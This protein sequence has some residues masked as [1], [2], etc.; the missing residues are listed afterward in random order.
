METAETAGTIFGD[1]LYQQR[2]RRALPLLVRQAIA[3]QTITYEALAREL[4]MPNPR[5]LNYVLGSIGETLSQLS[6]EWNQA[7]PKIQ[8]L[9]VNKNLGIPGEGIL[10]FLPEQQN[11]SQLPLKQKRSIVNTILSEVYVYPHWPKVLKELSLDPPKPLDPDKGITKL[12]NSQTYFGGGEGKQHKAL[13][14]RVAAHPALIG[15]KRNPISVKIEHIL[16]SGDS[17]D[18]HFLYKTESVAVEVKSAISTEADLRRGMFQCIKYQV[19]MEAEHAL[20]QDA[21]D[22][23]TLLVVEGRLSPELVAVKNTLGVEVIELDENT[24]L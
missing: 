20:A 12:F 19:V 23:K 13:K 16:A 24:K 4:E 2:A 14:E 11:F 5:N 7:I 1:K 21:K 15:L 18:I 9:V 6:T 10:P 17:L 8:A 3:G 22:I